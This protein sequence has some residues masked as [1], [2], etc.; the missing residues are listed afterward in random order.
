MIPYDTVKDGSNGLNNHLKQIDHSQKSPGNSKQ[1]KVAVFMKQHVP[2]TVRQRIFDK[3]A[4]WCATENR[5]FNIVESKTFKAVIDEIILVAVKYGKVDVNEIVPRKETVR[6]HA[7]TVYERLR[8]KLKNFS[9]S[10]DYVHATTDH[11][12]DSMSGASY[13]TVCI[14]YHNKEKRNLGSRIIET[15]E[16]GDKTAETTKSHF[17][18]ELNKLD[19][20]Q[21]KF[22]LLLDRNMLPNWHQLATTHRV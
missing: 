12:K 14:H 16:V 15:Y 11:W 5:P 17:R 2:M 1:P 18:D 4:I 10:I 21:T 13:M 22:S 20:S 6:Q 19:Y 8:L 9:G 7:S 3:F